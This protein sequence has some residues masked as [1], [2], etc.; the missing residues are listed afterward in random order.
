MSPSPTPAIVILGATSSI[1]RALAACYAQRGH[2]LILAAR[3]QDENEAIACD[4]FLR[5]QVEVHALHWDV[6]EF[7]EQADN[8][9]DGPTMRN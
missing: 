9:P 8:A 6:Q 3:D 5:H 7:D 4:I 2:T 1:A